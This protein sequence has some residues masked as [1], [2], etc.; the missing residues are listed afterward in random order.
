MLAPIAI[1]E[2]WMM[3][4]ERQFMV[5]MSLNGQSYKGILFNGIKAFIVL[6]LLRLKILLFMNFTKDS[7]KKNLCMYKIFHNLKK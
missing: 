6:C 7:N 5:A 2:G 4:E 3:A 1:I